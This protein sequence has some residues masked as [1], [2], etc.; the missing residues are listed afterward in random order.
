MRSPSRSGRPG[1]HGRQPSRRSPSRPAH[2]GLLASWRDEGAFLVLAVFL[3]L[4][5]LGGGSAFPDTLSLLYIRP[6]A[7]AAIAAFLLIPARSDE[8]SGWHAMLA[9]LAMLAVLAAIMVA[10]LIPLPPSAWAAL[11]GR[12]PY[13]AAVAAGAAQP[14]RP[15]SLTPDLT[16]NSL[17]ALVVPAAALAGLARL[18]P[19]GRDRLLPG[20]ILLCAISMAVGVA[21]FAG[22]E[23]SVLYTYKRTYPGTTTGLLANRNHQAAMLA[24]L[25]PALRCWTLM[26]APDRQWK[27]RRQWLALALGIAAVPVILAT[28]SR[29]GIVLGLAGLMAAWMLFPATRAANEAARSPWF[30]RFGIP[31]ALVLLVLATLRFGRA[32][33]IQRLTGTAPSTLALEDDLRFRLAPVVVQ[34]VRDFFPTGTGFGSFDPMFR[35]YEPDAVLI[36][37]YFNHA[38]NELLEIALTAG[39]AGLLLLLVFVCWWAVN[40]V[41][42]LRARP[43]THAA[44]LALLGAVM[45]GIMMA[46]SLVDYPLRTPLL[47]TWFA[48]ACGWMAMRH[49]DSASPTP[50]DKIAVADRPL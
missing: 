37:S 25:F 20:F 35:Q 44:R 21:Q 22:G 43:R 33:S 29:A 50:S 31:A 11:P 8:P 5:A 12:A 32:L 16:A 9:P 34:M 6:A 46:A 10:Q 14:W 42:A 1:S 40:L 41:G 38:H 30:L 45:V 28:G 17:A 2:L 19:A 18:S 27:R 15:L 47:E 36:S 49:L 26:P 48:L 39:I 7:V 3:L 24:A 4:V 23:Q 13:L